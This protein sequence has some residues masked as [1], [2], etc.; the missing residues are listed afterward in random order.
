MIEGFFDDRVDFMNSAGVRCSP[1]ESIVPIG[2]YDP[3]VD[4]FHPFGTG[5]FICTRGLVC[6]ARH[7]FEFEPQFMRQMSHLSPDAYLGIVQ[8]YANHTANVRRIVNVHAHN[9]FDLAIAVCEPLRNLKS[10]ETF[11]N[12]AQALSRRQIA[13]G[14]P[15]HQYSYPN[16][17]IHHDSK[18]L[19]TIMI[20]LSTAGIVIDWLPSGMG[21]LFPSP[22]YVIGGYIG[23]GSSGGPVLDRTGAAVAVCSR[24]CEGGNYYYAIPIRESAEIIMSSVGLSTGPVVVAPTIQQM[25]SRKLIS[26]VD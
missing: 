19:D 12:A 4:L 25:A 8:Y 20:P 3:H 1:L 2:F 5:I 13:I 7:V 21:S 10:G 9:Q 16:P 26:F 14:E 11:H 24:G 6:T 15:V 18:K 22:A 23:A 17:I